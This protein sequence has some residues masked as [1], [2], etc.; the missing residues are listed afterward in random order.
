MTADQPDTIV[1]QYKG[2]EIRIRARRFGLHAWR[3]N[4]RICGAKHQALQSLAATLRESDDGV[5]KQAAMLGAFL[6]AMSLCDL[7]LEK[8]RA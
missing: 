3:C 6:E 1:D 7:L 2:M 8:R 5:S 4:I